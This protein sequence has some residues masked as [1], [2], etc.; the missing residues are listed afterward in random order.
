MK[1]IWL[2][3]LSFIAIFFVWISFADVIEPN[4]HYVDKCVKIENPHGIPWYKL[5]IW[6]GEFA[7]GRISY[8]VY[9]VVENECL[10]NYYQWWSTSSVEVPYLIDENIDV[11]ALNDDKVE[12]YSIKE[13]SI[14]FESKLWDF[15]KFDKIDPN[16]YY[17]Y[18]FNPLE[19]ETITY[20]IVKNW[21]NYALEWADG[22]GTEKIK[23]EMN[24]ALEIVGSE[25]GIA[26][27]ENK[28]IKFWIARLITIL[29]ETIVLFII[30]KLFRKNDQI[31][32]WRI[33]LIWILA[34][35]ITLP[36][37]RFVLPLFIVDG[38]EYTIIWELSVIL[39][40]I[41]IIKYWLKISRCK[42]ILASI[43]CNLCSYLIGLL[44]F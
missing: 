1:K 7:Y 26:M 25:Q 35:T 36:L 10:P 18:D 6:R 34:S 43:V 9:D 20:K 3:V 2:F 21:D 33:L 30:A 39:I 44:I 37:L 40:E 17:V 15:I 41:L 31:S 4:T 32:N 11:S 27:P 24:Y 28:L 5:I 13:P 12:I 38:I 42:A 19:S 23:G 29:I 14:E 22:E 16:G 8:S